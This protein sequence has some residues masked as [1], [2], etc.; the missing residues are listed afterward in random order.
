MLNPLTKRRIRSWLRSPG[1]YVK[2][3]RDEI[4]GIDT[5]F[6]EGSRD[7]FVSG[8]KEWLALTEFAYGGLKRGAATKTMQGGDRMSPRQHAYGATYAEFLKPWIGKSPNLLEVGILNGTGL[9]IWCDL[10]P[11][12]QVIGMDINLENFQANL[13][14]LRRL[15]AFSEN[16][17]KLYEFNQLE[18][19]KARRVLSD[20]IGEEP[21]DVVIDDGCHSIESIE[22]TFQSVAPHLAPEFVYFI[23]DNYDT[24]DLLSKKFP[25]Y[26]WQTRGEMTIVM[27]F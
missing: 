15:G 21:L 9:A 27:S 2:R 4:F 5:S 16:Q 24:Y 14:Q 12:S 10:F 20:A 25:D 6:L 1:F 19:D 11:D 13:S 3:A 7:A 26:R 23:E 17:P 18:L 22:I 8:S